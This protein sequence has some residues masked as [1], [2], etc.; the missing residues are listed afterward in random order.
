[1]SFEDRDLGFKEILK[2]LEAFKKK[3]VSVGI[4]EDSGK[5][6]S[7]ESIAQTAYK[8]EFGIGVRARPA[9]RQ[10]FDKNRKKLNDLNLRFLRAITDR[11]MKAL[12]A[13]SLLG[14]MHQNNVRQ[15]IVDLRHPR[16]SPK[17]IELK[18]SSNPLIDTGQTRQSVRWKID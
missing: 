2:E 11:K 4:F 6:E 16:N 9:H 12:R 17:T 8:N 3:T 14:E 10:A 13:L 7:G 18:G 15:R 5:H 1:M